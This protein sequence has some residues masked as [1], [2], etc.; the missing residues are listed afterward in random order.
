MWAAADPLSLLAKGAF[1]TALPFLP[2]DF[3][4]VVHFFSLIFWFCSEDFL[5]FS[6]LQLVCWVFYTI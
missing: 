1:C 6:L 4:E 3:Y 2:C 5:T